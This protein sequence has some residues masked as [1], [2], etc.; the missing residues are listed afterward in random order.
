[1]E[2]KRVRGHIRPVENLGEYRKFALVI[3]AILVFSSI[4]TWLRGWEL[5]IFMSDFMAV[6][7]I[8][9]AGFKFA[10]LEMFVMH[11]KT[12]DIL[13]QKLWF[14]G[15]AF[16][17]IEGMLGIAYLLSPDSNLV[18]LTA[19]LITG[20]AGVGVWKELQ[21]RSEIM[22]ACLGNIIRLPLSK[23]SFI[24]DAAMFTMALIMILI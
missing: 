16:P 4:L 11:Y 20:T 15:Y 1:M 8:T 10:N 2:Y 3:L 19:M 22:C 14:W 18:N 6:F 7:F 24:E 13:A 12:Y 23:V 21:N 9:F 17:F 5:G